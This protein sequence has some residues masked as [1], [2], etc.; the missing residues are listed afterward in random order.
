MTTKNGVTSNIITEFKNCKKDDFEM[1]GYD[2]DLSAIGVNKLLCPD[3]EHL[4]D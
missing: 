2:E 4:K 3:V 1:N